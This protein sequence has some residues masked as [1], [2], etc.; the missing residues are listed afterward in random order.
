MIEA[1]PSDAVAMALAAKVPVYTT[2]QVM[3]EGGITRA[4][5][6]ASGRE[7]GDALPGRG[8]SG[9][10]GTAPDPPPSPGA[11]KATISPQKKPVEL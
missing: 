2:R 9:T 7:P 10:A 3:A 8:G 6:D 1:R 11:S 4:E 5:I